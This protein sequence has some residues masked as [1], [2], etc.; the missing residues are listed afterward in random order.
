M[1][2]RYNELCCHKLMQ[3]SMALERTVRWSTAL[4]IASSLLTGPVS[5]F[6]PGQSTVMASASRGL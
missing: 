2:C 6:H 4:L 1:K 3:S 5:Y